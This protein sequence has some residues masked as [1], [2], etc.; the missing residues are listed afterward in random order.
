MFSGMNI[1]GKFLKKP[2]CRAVG[3]CSLAKVK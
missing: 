1:G 2:W 3:G